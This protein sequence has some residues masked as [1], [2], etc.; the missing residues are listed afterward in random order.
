MTE[1]QQIAVDALDVVIRGIFDCEAFDRVEIVAEWVGEEPTVHGV[2]IRRG[3][4]AVRFLNT[5]PLVVN[6][7][8]YVCGDYF[9]EAAKSFLV[10]VL[11]E[12]L[13]GHRK[14]VGRLIAFGRNNRLEK[15]L[16]DEQSLLAAGKRLYPQE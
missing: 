10:E 2:T 16:A 14:S 8:L 13:R 5:Q 1:R 15:L 7:T 12:E 4:A 9:I 11:D 3:E 6:G